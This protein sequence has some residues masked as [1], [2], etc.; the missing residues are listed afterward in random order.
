MIGGFY[1]QW[2]ENA[3]EAARSKR[4]QD[5]M[6]KV[7]ENTNRNVYDLSRVLQ[8]LGKSTISL[9][10]T[11]N[12]LE[13]QEFCEAASKEGERKKSASPGSSYFALPDTDWSKWPDRRRIASI[14]LLFFKSKDSAKNYLGGN[15]LGCLGG[16][17]NF[18]VLF[19]TA[20][21]THDDRSVVILTYVVEYSSLG[22]AAVNQDLSPSING[23]KMLSTVDLSGATSII[24]GHSGLFKTIA[25]TAISI[26]TDSGRTI[27]I[28]DPRVLK[29]KDDTLFEY[30]F[31]ESPQH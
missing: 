3:S 25:L 30:E 23:D 24:Y 27:E 4:S 20:P 15:C 29:V 17:M 22:I 21:T 13:V 26:K 8:P 6:L 7:I 5:D 10:F 19:N 28:E 14:D 12:C 31:P 18:R 1:A 2:E 11:L 9:F 16:D